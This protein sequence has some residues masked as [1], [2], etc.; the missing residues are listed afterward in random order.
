LR[1]LA[2]RTGRLDL[3]DE[4]NHSGSAAASADKVISER[5]RGSGH[6]LSGFS[7]PLSQVQP[8][9]GGTADRVVVTVTSSS[10][11]YEEKDAQGTVVATGAASPGQQLRLVLVSV[12]G[13]WL[14]SEILPGK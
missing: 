14:V 11:A 2:F 4:V 10:S 7:S 5:L 1:S 6:T 12:D 13:R 3:L 8:E 9:P